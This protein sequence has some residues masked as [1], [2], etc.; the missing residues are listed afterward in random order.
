MLRTRHRPD[1]ALGPVIVFL[2]KRRHK[3]SG[4]DICVA[5]ASMLH[6]R[7]HYMLKRQEGADLHDEGFLPGKGLVF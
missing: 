2:L 5:A 1:T 3:R 4:G 7:Y 6:M